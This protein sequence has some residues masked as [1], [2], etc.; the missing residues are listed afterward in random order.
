MSKLARIDSPKNEGS[1]SCV[2][3][4]LDGFSPAHQGA[5][6]WLML[7]SDS[8]AILPANHAL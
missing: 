3:F 1:N 4:S 6:S 8:D 7:A 5:A 2:L